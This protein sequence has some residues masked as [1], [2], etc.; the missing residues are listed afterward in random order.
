MIKIQVTKEL[1]AV[2]KS[3]K[4]ILKEIKPKKVRV[5]REKI[6]KYCEFINESNPI[7]FDDSYAK[8]NSYPKPLIPISYF[9][10]LITPI[11]QEIFIRGLAKLVKGIIHT[12]SEIHHFKPLFI[13][14]FYTTT[15]KVTD[16]IKKRGKK[17]SYFQTNFVISLKD[18]E[19]EE[20][21]FD[22]HMFFLK[23]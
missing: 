22:K 3:I 21:A 18:D 14:T 23:R 4:K 6:K 13:D 5:T 20:L 11:I 7:Y 17:G 19:G 12:F 15:L 8:S 10:T 1:I 9:P 16:I 2:T